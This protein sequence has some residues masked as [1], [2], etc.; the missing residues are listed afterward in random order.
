MAALDKWWRDYEKGTALGQVHY[1]EPWKCKP[2]LISDVTREDM[3]RSTQK[4][5]AVYAD[6]IVEVCIMF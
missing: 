4:N 3:Q 6:L 1:L 5:N 2:T